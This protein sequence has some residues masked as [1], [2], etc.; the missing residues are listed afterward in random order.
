MGIKR[1]DP[2]PLLFGPHVRSGG[3]L[4]FHDSPIAVI[5]QTIERAIH[6]GFNLVEVVN[7]LTVLRR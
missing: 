6:D 5:K 1:P 3:L 4:L 7:S 2:Y